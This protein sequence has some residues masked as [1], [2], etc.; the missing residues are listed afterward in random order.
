MLWSL[1]TAMKEDIFHAQQLRDTHVP[2]CTECFYCEKIRRL[3]P[4]GSEE[5]GV[6]FLKKLKL[7]R[8]LYYNLY[9]CVMQIFS[10][11][12]SS[13]IE[14]NNV[15]LFFAFLRESNCGFGKNR[16]DEIAS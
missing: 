13:K 2:Q 5:K 11:H 7:G 10:Q 16:N 9:F 3:F 6:I 12:L 8:I 4:E 14:E 1:G 15:P